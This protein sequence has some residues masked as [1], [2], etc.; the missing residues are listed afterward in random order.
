MLI[1]LAA[2]RARATI[3]TRGGELH[4]W[5]AGGRDLLWNRDP[6]WWAKSSPILFPIV[7]WTNQG[8]IRV[9]GKVRPMGVHGFAAASE[10]TVVERG[11]AHLTLELTETAETLEVY[12]YPF[13]L[14]VTYRLEESRL[15]VSFTVANSG[16]RALPYALGL[17]PAFLWPFAGGARDD[18][19]ILFEKPE[20]PEVPV[21]APGGLV[22]PARRPVP[23]DGRRLAL[24]DQLF[25]S[26]ALCF[27]DA[28]SR[29]FAFAAPGGQPSIALEA[30]DF[31]H[32]ALWTKPGAPFVSM[33]VWTGHGDPEGYEGELADKPSMRHL[34]PGAEARHAVDFVYQDAGAADRQ[35]NEFHGV[36]LI[37]Y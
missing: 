28:Q 5:H 12:P 16:K 34:A 18:Y 20:R 17:H 1:D 6:A 4:A 7:G 30:E 19:A 15:S 25:A 11:V 8:R 21:I 23:L 13:R 29:S 31:P 37:F 36:Q 32:L 27:L 14:A 10:F 22:S 33:E 24:A 35:R 3:A 9:D 26:D 2:G